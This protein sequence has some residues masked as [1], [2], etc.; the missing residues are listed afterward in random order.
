LNNLNRSLFPDPF[1]LYA[2]T[3][4]RSSTKVANW[5]GFPVAMGIAIFCNEGMVIISPPVHHAMGNPAWKT[6]KK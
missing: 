4:M 3:L 6:F 5:E 2:Q 1:V